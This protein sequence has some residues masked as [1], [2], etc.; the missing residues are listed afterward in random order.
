MR[1]KFHMLLGVFLAVCFVTASFG[2]TTFGTITGTVTDPSGAVVPNAKIT[3]TNE[4]DRTTRE[5]VTSSAGVFCGAE[6]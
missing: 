2:Q 3:I 1:R 5:V 6:P 4:G